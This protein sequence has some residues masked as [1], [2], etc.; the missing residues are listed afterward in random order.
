MYG[1]PN[2]KLDKDVVERRVQQMR[3]E[4]VT[5]VTCAHVGKS[6][7]FAS[8]H[9]TEIMQAGGCDM[10]FI[11]PQELV[12]NNDAVLLAV[13]ATKPFDPVGRCPGRELG[14]IYFAMDFLT[15]NT[16]SLL[17]TQLA[18]GKFTSANGKT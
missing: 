3:A 14:G 13:G 7:D 18:D 4:G 5:F 8:G 12:D 6:A 10:Q 15:R 16:K 2:M 17:D 9:M 1:I 11:D